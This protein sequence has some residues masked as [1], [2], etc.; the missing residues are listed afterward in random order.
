MNNAPGAVVDCEVEMRLRSGDSPG[1]TTGIIML[2]P[3][4]PQND[5]MNQSIAEVEVE[6]SV[7]SESCDRHLI[8]S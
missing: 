5:R 6:E 2:A 8:E 4:N 1:P 3:E 7:N